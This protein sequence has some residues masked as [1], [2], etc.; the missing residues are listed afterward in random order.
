[1]EEEPGVRAYVHCPRAKTTGGIWFDGSLG[2]FV[3][4]RDGQ[5]ETLSGEHVAGGGTCIAP[6]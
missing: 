1:M 3:Q 5:E 4:G 6:V 2:G